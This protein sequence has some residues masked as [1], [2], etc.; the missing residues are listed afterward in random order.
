LQETSAAAALYPVDVG[1]VDA[2]APKFQALLHFLDAAEERNH[3]VGRR[4]HQ[5][6]VGPDQFEGAHKIFQGLAML[7]EEGR[8][9]LK[10]DASFGFAEEQEELLGAIVQGV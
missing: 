7:I 2:L 3:F 1:A 4:F 10:G 9:S 5:L 8:V 6:Q